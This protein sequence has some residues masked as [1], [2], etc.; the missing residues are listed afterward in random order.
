VFFAFIEAKRR[1]LTE[2]AGGSGAGFQQ[3]GQRFEI[4]RSLEVV[5]YDWSC[6][7]KRRGGKE[8]VVGGDLVNLESQPVGLE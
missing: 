5:L 4:L 8:E 2:E 1:A 6:E 3:E 7:M